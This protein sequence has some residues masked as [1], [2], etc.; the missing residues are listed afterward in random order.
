MCNFHVFAQNTYHTDNKSNILNFL[1]IT[2][3]LYRNKIM[4]VYC[5]AV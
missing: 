1:H 4:S 3:V 5:W 2:L